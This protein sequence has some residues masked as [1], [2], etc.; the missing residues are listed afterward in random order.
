MPQAQA[1][2]S[3]GPVRK[4]V[5][6]RG[7]GPSLKVNGVAIPGVLQDP[8][9]GLYDSSGTLVAMNDNWRS[10][11]EMQIEATGLAPTDDRESA[12]IAELEPDQ[13]T[14][15]IRGAGNTTGIGLL[16]VYDLQPAASNPLTNLSM[17][18]KVETG[19]DVLIGGIIAGGGNRAKIL[20]RAIGPDLA[21]DGVMNPL[22]DPTLE[23]YDTNGDL[24]A[25]NDNWK[26]TQ[27]QEITATGIPPSDDRDSAIL[28]ILPSENYTVVVRGK[29]NGNTPATG[30]AIVEAYNL[31]PVIP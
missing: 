30:V 31:G 1:A 6:I 24:L 20:F 4:Q 15:I 19:D 25:S 18:G 21:D 3:P 10:T 12:I 11:Q 28:K 17:R 29:S 16:E 23:L 7:L 26:D 5:I 14:A 2:P 8:T 9:L 13:Y 27:E 22:N